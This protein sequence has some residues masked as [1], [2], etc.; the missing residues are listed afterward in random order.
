MPLVDMPLEDLK[1]YRGTNP[2]PEDFDEYWDSSVREM[3]SINPK[4]ELVLSDFK[5]PFA[6]CYDLYYTG[7][8]GARIHAKLV[9]PRNVFE[10][11]PAELAFHGYSGRSPEWGGLLAMAASGFVSVAMDCRGQ[12]GESEDVGHHKGNTLNGH[13][14]RGLEDNNPKR[15]LFRDI[16]LDTA[17][18]AGI[19]M[20]LDFVDEK[21]VVARGGS[22]GGALTLA[23][24]SLEPKIKLAFAT[25]P[26]LCDYKR[27][28]EMD[29]AERA[30]AELK[31]YFRNF[32]PK[33]EREDLIFTKLGYIDVQFLV[34]RIKAKVK[35]V[36]GLMDD[37]CPPSTQFAAFNKMLC[38]KES[39][40]YPDF[41]HEGLPGEWEN[42][43]YMWVL[44]EFNIEL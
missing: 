14:I 3:R 27:V 44:N 39:I 43:Y 23:C 40:I 6:E 37:V 8:G 10:P 16:F 29:M 22:Q 21:R 18:L 41:G 31:R 7:I 26:F 24:A 12:A 33:H 19:V 1:K 32:D 2:K 25:Y 20:K 35:M 34:P 9:K 11:C 28:W 15:L 36:T 30:Y 4:P 13:I 17:E 38:E 5:T 42:D